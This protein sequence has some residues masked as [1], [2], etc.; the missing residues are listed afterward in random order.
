MKLPDFIIIGAMKCGTTVLWHN[1]NKHPD[2]FMGKN[3][4]DPK[5]TST[6]IRFWN[7]GSPHHVWKNGINWYKKLF[8]KD[9]C[10]G[11]KCANYIEE[12]LTFKRMHKHIPNAKLILC[13]RN[14]ADRMYSEYQ[15]QRHT[16]GLSEKYNFAKDV[17]YTHRGKYF[18]MIKRNVLPYYPKESIHIVIQERMKDDVT[19]EMNKI[20][21]F[22][23]LSEHIIPVQKVSVKQKDEKI[24]DYKKW[25]SDYKNLDPSIR[26]QLMKLFEPHNQKL[27]DFMGATVKEWV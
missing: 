5:K 15:M 7:D 16:Q 20:F 18:E 13:V 9:K 3:L 8:K 4:D 24:K 2:I 10:C 21:K 27:F 12:N 6:E 17:G 1:L 19:G 22:L 23:D 14:P 11:E 26:Q 25:S